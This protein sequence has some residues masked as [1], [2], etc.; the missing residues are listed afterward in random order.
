MA[1]LDLRQLCVLQTA[2]DDQDIVIIA[3]TLNTITYFHVLLSSFGSEW[4]APR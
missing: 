1:V 3:A 4:E 2:A